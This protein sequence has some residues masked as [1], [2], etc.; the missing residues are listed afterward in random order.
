MLARGWQVNEQANRPLT[1][2][3]RSGR[4]LC[5]EGMQAPQAPPR[6]TCLLAAAAPLL[7]SLQVLRRGR[8]SQE[9]LAAAHDVVPHCGRAGTQ[10]LSRRG[11]TL[12]HGRMAVATPGAAS[13]AGAR[14]LTGGQGMPVRRRGRERLAIGQG[15]ACPGLPAARPATGLARPRR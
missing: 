2:N 8:C 5:G 11:T 12:R 13:P 9:D 7:K 6:H 4:D 15:H 1:D 14:S 10:K 3:G